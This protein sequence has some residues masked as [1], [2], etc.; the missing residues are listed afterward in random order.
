LNKPIEPSRL[1]RNVDLY[2]E[3]TPPVYRAKRLSMRQIEIAEA[4]GKGQAAPAG[5]AQ[6]ALPGQGPAGAPS[7]APSPVVAR[8]CAAVPSSPAPAAES[9]TTGALVPRILLVEDDRDLTDLLVA[10]LSESFE[11]VHAADGLQAVEKMVKYQPDLM[12]VDVMLPKMNGYQLCQSVRGNVAYAN[13][14][15]LVLTAK[16]GAKD[17]EYALKMGADAFLPKPAEMKE[18]VECCVALSRR[19]GFQVRP[20]KQSAFDI[21]AEQAQEEMIRKDRDEKLKRLGRE[22]PAPG[23]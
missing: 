19:P 9:L 14:P 7:G 2:F 15:I 16:T 18:L 21:R 5:A 4:A 3:Q 1:V 11:V 17:R 22:R 12:I 8:A 6:S 23:S 10:A 20:K 13:V